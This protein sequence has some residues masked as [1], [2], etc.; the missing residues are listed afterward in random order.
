MN[1]GHL[2][3]DQSYTLG[4][5]RF[6]DKALSCLSR[7]SIVRPSSAVACPSSVAG[8]CGGQATEDGKADQRVAKNLLD[9]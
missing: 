6:L 8:Y 7:H 9:G 5:V 3:S 2:S 4:V 1:I